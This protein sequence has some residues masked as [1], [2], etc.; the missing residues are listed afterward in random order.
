LDLGQDAACLHDP[1]YLSECGRF[2][3]GMGCSLGRRT[4]GLPRLYERVPDPLPLQVLP[5]LLEAHASVAQLAEILR[6]GA[7]SSPLPWSTAAALASPEARPFV[8]RWAEL[9]VS[10]DARGYAQR[11][12]AESAAI[13]R[14]TPELASALE[15]LVPE[16]L[17]S[18]LPNIEVEV[19]PCQAL[20]DGGR[21]VTPFEG[22]FHVATRVPTAQGMPMAR[23]LLQI[24]HELTHLATDPFLSARD[25]RDPSN[26]ASVTRET[27]R[28]GRGFGIHFRLEQGVLTVDYHLLR[29]R[30]PALLPA[31]LEW[32][33]RWILPA[34]DDRGGPRL[35]TLAE[36]AGIMKPSS[37]WE[38]L[39]RVARVDRPAAIEAALED[40]LLIP[41]AAIP[42]LEALAKR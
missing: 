5:L 17:G 11:W 34:D 32:C 36:A 28:D 41:E 1:G 14:A 3:G 23:T 15:E 24:V 2:E 4:R 25:E 10:E 42:A 27:R 7:D 9:L 29:R 6:A 20:V 13:S 22:R 40:W 35:R 39:L 26:G 16:L 33:G 37:A 8:E 21:G 18:L 38:A 30:C 31:Y 12:S 19:R